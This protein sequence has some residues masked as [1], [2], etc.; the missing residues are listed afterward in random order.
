MMTAPSSV[1]VHPRRLAVGLA[2][3][4]STLATQPTLAQETTALAA[5]LAEAEENAPEIRVARR[6]AE[7]AAARVPQAG[8]LPDPTLTFGLMNF[9]IAD[10]SLGREMMT[11]TTVQLGERV[12]W[13]GKR[14]LRESVAESSA[15]AAEWEVERTRQ[16]VR[17]DLKSD[18]YQIYFLDRAMEVTERNAGL[19]QDLAELTSAAYA[20]GRA[21]QPDVLRAQVERSRLTDQLVVLREQRASVRSRLN[22]RLGRP[23]ETALTGVELPTVLRVAALERGPGSTTFASSALSDALSNATTPTAPG[24]ASVAQ[25]QQLALAH[26]PTIQAHV[27]RIAA[28]RNALSLAEK[29]KLPDINFALTYSRRADFTDFVSFTVAVPLPVFAGRKQTQGVVEQSA[30]VA[31]HEARLDAMVNQVNADISSLA[32]RLGRAR[33]QLLLL[34]DGILPQASTTLASATASYRVGDAD[35]LTLLDAQA[36]LYRH[37]LDVHRLLSDFASNLAELERAVGTEVLR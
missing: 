20:V 34:N 1:F 27:E 28:Q 9:P 26:N 10:P 5:L 33:D 3:V 25:L 4:T 12:P 37:E 8:A 11:M 15:A 7:A 22:S 36:T 21:A 18:Y 23:T 32:A 16:Q 31:E 2:L 19:L 35:F 17:T 13:P 14:G 6:S 29:A 24:I 30:V